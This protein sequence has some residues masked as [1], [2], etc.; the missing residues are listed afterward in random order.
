MLLFS[1]NVADKIMLIE[2]FRTSNDV[3]PDVHNDLIIV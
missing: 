3:S 1:R 2:S